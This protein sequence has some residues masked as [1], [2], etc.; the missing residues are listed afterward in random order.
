MSGPADAQ[1]LLL[2]SDR[3][4]A[5]MDVSS[6]SAG[7]RPSGRLSWSKT[8]WGTATDA[9]CASPAATL[10]SV[11]A[12]PWDQTDAQGTR[13]TTVGPS[14]WLCIR[15]G[16]GTERTRRRTRRRPAIDCGCR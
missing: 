13:T 15:N 4:Y 8:A 16:A 6:N 3:G 9:D 12:A 2:P 10:S 7:R 1:P 11:A 14:G 5:N